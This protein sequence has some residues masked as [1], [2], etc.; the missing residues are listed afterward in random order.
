MY[1]I[2]LMQRNGPM[3]VGLATFPYGP[4]KSGQDSDRLHADHLIP[5]LHGQ[6]SLPESPDVDLDTG[7]AEV[8]NARPPCSPV[9]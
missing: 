3:V 2:R 6:S 5:G 9:S 7:R 4:R 1:A 8:S